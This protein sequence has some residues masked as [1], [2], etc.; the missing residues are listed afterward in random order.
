[1]QRVRKPQGARSRLRMMATY[2]I[3]KAADL[4]CDPDG[5][6]WVIICQ[7]HGLIF[8]Y[9]TKKSA[10]YSAPTIC[11]DQCSAFE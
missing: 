6:K 4:G 11:G 1:M 10:I 8:N 9:P 3:G 5:G 2:T 7:V